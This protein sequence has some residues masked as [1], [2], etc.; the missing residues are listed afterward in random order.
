MSG[1]ASSGV[2]LALPVTGYWALRASLQRSELQ[3]LLARLPAPVFLALA[4]AA[5]I[6]L[7]SLPI[8][9]AAELGIYHPAG[10]GL[11]GW[12]VTAA[13][14]M[15]YLKTRQRVARPSKQGSSG[16]DW[17][18]AAGLAFAAI[19][20]FGFPTESI[21]GSIDQGVYANTAT[22]LAREGHLDVPYP[23]RGPEDHLP[24]FLAP[25][26]FYDTSP[27]LTP[28]FAHL[29]PAWLAQA[30]ASLGPPGLFRL[31]GF[32]ALVALLCFYGTCHSLMP[33]PYAVIATLLLALNP[34]QIWLARI[35][36]SEI[37]A[38]L[39][40]WAGILFLYQAF[41]NGIAGCARWA[42]LALGLSALVR[43][44]GFLLLPLLFL[45]HFVFAIVSSGKPEQQRS[46]P[47][48]EIYQTAIPAFTAAFVY[49]LFFSHRYFGDLSAQLTWILI[50]CAAT[51]YPLLAASAG[52]LRRCRR[53][54]SD[55]RTLIIFTALVLT[56]AAYAY[57]V[58]PIPMDEAGD[59][60][61]IAADVEE[62]PDLNLRRN[63]MVNLAR[64]L[65]PLVVWLAIIGSC[66]VFWSVLAKASRL[67]AVAILTIWAGF[68]LLY[69]Y[70]PNIAP[71]H[72]WAIRRFVPV[73]IPGFLLFAALGIH[74]GLKFIP[75]APRRVAAAILITFLSLFTARA[76]RPLFFDAEYAGVVEQLQE[77]STALPLDEIVLL[78]V[79]RRG[80]SQLATPLYLT[81]GHRIFPFYSNNA[82]GMEAMA[83]H[84]RRQHDLGKPAYLL[85]EGDSLPDDWRPPMSEVRRF[86]V[87][88]SHI[89]PTVSPIPRE[90]VSR[91]IPL[92]LY[93][94]G[95]SV[96]S[97]SAPD[98]PVKK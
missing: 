64:Y 81:F 73:V 37:L 43:I 4:I 28:Q 34:S 18:L 49:Y 59:I 84:W 94:F 80:W 16:W 9:L 86:T 1:L 29:F 52:V 8:L 40:I 23:W 87:R 30:Q 97:R 22:F 95:V 2:W 93:K 24:G 6:M 42:G 85:Y 74:W 36:L 48:T 33:K 63:S 69:L 75:R 62:P 67:G 72:F 98:P 50:A 41:E 14:S 17:L 56:A 79:T 21:L 71:R 54:L 76:S 11:A 39:L 3:Q 10:L 57:W 27:T 88:F 89:R 44:D 51:L 26:G 83:A 15:A 90:F 45:A 31:N 7:W 66:A 96:E 38:Q 60:A 19:Q 20:Y 82:K 25:I 58:R 35:T 12:I 46:G 68:T 65:S 77:V 70:D 78:P 55:R 13:G 32:F 92:I 5:G 47:W 91:E 61:A 53:V